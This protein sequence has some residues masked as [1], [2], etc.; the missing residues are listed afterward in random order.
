MS[1][2]TN[3]TLLHDGFGENFKIIIYS[4]LYS[5]FNNMKFI[6]SPLETIEHNYCDDP[7]YINQIEDMINFKSNFDINISNS[8]PL[9]MFLIY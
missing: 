8:N 6:Y 5:E 4:L 2:V 7:E 1:Y 3:P 9:L